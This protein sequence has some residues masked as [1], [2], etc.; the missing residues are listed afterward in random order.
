MHLRWIYRR[1]HVR[2]L[3]TVYKHCWKSGDMWRSYTTV[4]LIKKMIM[5]YWNL[6]STQ[7]SYPSVGYTSYIWLFQYNSNHTSILCQGRHSHVCVCMEPSP[8]RSSWQSKMRNISLV[9]G[10][11]KVRNYSWRSHESCSVQNFIVNS[12]NNFDH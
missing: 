5:P 8:I 4:D 2:C 7:H 10:P 11:S 1:N 9:N 3:E 6:Y 12:G